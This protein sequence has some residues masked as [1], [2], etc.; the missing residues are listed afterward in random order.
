MCEVLQ[1]K[2]PIPLVARISL[3]SRFEQRV[4]RDSRQSTLLG[5]WD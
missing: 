1:G 5:A 4:R 2:L 3:A